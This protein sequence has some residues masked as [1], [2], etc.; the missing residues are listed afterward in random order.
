MIKI[1]VVLTTT[2]GLK[3]LHQL[4]AL[5]KQE[6]KCQ[7]KI[8][9]LKLIESAHDNGLRMAARLRDFEEKLLS[10]MVLWLRLRRFL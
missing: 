6:W 3:L 10:L 5:L 7:P 9:R 4:N 1:M 2:D 8:C